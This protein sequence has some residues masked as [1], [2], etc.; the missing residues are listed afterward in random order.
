MN[1]L[2]VDGSEIGRRREKYYVDQFL[3]KNVDYKLPL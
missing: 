1:Q 2:R 3:I